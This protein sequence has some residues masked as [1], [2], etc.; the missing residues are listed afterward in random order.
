M[1]FRL[2]TWHRVAFLLLWTL[3]V[4]YPNPWRLVQSVHRVFEPPVGAAAVEHLLPEVPRDPAELEAHVLAEYP[5]RYDWTTYRV[6]WYFPTVDEA[7]KRGEG[8]CKTRF[9]ILASLF[10]ALDVRYVQTFSI[11]HFWLT[12]EGKEETPLEKDSNAWLVRGEDGTR[13]KVPREDAQ[14]IWRIFREAFWDAMPPLRKVMFL[15]GVPLA[16]LL[17]LPL[18]LLGRVHRGAVARIAGE[19]LS[20]H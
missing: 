17:H 20:M 19:R 11:S 15:A 8:D 6:P 7:L 2:R 13:L 9:V 14:Q 3:L 10:E 5:Y 18:A 1:T 16:A 4:L 12:Y